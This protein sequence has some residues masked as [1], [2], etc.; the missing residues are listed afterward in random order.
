MGCRPPIDA[1][2]E[3][4]NELG[5]RPSEVLVVAVAAGPLPC[6]RDGAGLAM[7]SARWPDMDD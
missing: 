2:V 4:M 3:I 7:S 1:L 5:K 6:I